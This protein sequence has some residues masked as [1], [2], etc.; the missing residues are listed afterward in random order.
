MPKD[1]DK[2]D[3]NLIMY[4]SGESNLIKILF[5]SNFSLCTSNLSKTFSS[6]KLYK[7]SIKASSFSTFKLRTPSFSNL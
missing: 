5:V 2:S 3:S 1:L 7:N 4:S 6:P